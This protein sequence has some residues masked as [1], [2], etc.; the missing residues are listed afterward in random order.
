MLA[1][2]S[3]NGFNLWKIEVTEKHGA[4]LF[5]GPRDEP[6]LSYLAMR[7]VVLTDLVC[8]RLQTRKRDGPVC[9]LLQKIETANA[10]GVNQ[11]EAAAKTLIKNHDAL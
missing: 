7:G 2:R 6:V 8:G 5:V 9:R 3:D 11:A 1:E 10:I 4:N